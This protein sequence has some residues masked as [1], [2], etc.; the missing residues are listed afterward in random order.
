MVSAFRLHS[1]TEGDRRAILSRNYHNEKEVGEGIRKSGV[2]REEL[3]VR[4]LIMS[5]KAQRLI[6]FLKVTT[7][8]WPTHYN[9]VAKALDT[10]LA[11]FGL[12]YID[13]TSELWIRCFC[14]G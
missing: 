7:K 14:S 2:P 3:F 1:C 4:P 12:E 9:D 8:V 11:N 5:C 6:F 13:C 10:S